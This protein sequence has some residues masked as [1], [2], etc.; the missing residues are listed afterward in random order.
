M[1]NKWTPEHDQRLLELKASG[2]TNRQIGVKLGGITKSSVERRA[3]HLKN[4]PIVAAPP[5]AP[6]PST[7]PI[8][9]MFLTANTCRW[10][11]WPDDAAP[12]GMF[13]GAWCP[14]PEMQRPYC[15]K[16]SGFAYR[17]ALPRQHIYFKF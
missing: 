16:H 6:E 3:R 8:E 13:C 9:L 11:V 7:A 5:P 12:T 1:W 17:G 14:G 15:A 10:P 2:L 4:K